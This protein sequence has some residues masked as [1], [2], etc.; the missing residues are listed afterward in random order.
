MEIWRKRWKK[1]ENEEIVE[2]RVNKRRKRVE[3]GGQRVE[4]G[5]KR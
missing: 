1:V 2:K 4:K 5:R 3:K